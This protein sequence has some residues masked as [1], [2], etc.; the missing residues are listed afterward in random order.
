MKIIATVAALALTLTCSAQK[1]ARIDT[2]PAILEISYPRDLHNRYKVRGYIVWRVYKNV[3]EITEYLNSEK[4]PFKPLTVIWSS[5]SR[6]YL[7]MKK[8]TQ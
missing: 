2:L 8:P 5:E 1:K 3:G 7:K 4:A 6:S